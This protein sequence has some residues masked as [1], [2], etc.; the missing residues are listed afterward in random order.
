MNNLN[1][2]LYNKN[3]EACL[4]T[5]NKIGSTDYWNV[6]DNTVKSVPW[7]SVDWALM[8]TAGII[9][10]VMICFFIKVVREVSGL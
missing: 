8:I 6:C 7:G 10:I 5:V 3:L 9:G 1:I 4:K 2:D